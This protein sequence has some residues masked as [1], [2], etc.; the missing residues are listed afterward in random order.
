MRVL[1][2]RPRSALVAFGVLILLGTYG[3]DRTVAY[4]YS[5]S[6]G[7][8][9]LHVGAFAVLLAGT[10]VLLPRIT[11]R[12]D[13][14]AAVTAVLALTALYLLAVAVA[15]YDLAVASSTPTASDPAFAELAVDRLVLPLLL[16]PLVS[17]YVLGAFDAVPA[18]GRS[19][20][21]PTFAVALVVV[22]P[23]GANAAAASDGVHHGLTFLGYVMM[24]VASV[25]VAL[26]FYLVARWT[27][28]VNEG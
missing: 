24:A 1:R 15:W 19:A 18:D 11:G 23:V 14:R 28:A 16:T 10:T 7:A 21:V 6:F 27:Y 3:L 12:P 26:V 4:G 20:A 5:T 17:G 25:V 22:G 2:R 13:Y 9:A 8:Y